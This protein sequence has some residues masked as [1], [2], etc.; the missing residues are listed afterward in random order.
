M[1]IFRNFAINFV[2]SSL[3]PIGKLAESCANILFRWRLEDLLDLEADP[4]KPSTCVLVNFSLASEFGRT[5]L[6]SLATLEEDVH[7]GLPQGC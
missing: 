3:Q 4:L 5:D 1:G 6:H 2:V 7:N